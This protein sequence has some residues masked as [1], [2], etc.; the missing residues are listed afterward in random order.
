[1]IG[2][3]DETAALV[4]HHDVAPGD[5][6]RYEAWLRE[7]ASEAQRF[8]GHMGVNI[9]R[10]QDSS[11]RYTIVLRFDSNEHLENWLDSAT[12]KRFI[13]EIRPMLAKN[14]E[15]EIRTGLEYWFTPPDA[16]RPN[17]RPI[18]QFLLTL[19]AIFPLTVVLPWLLHPVFSAVPLFRYPLVT[20]FVLAVLIV[21]LMVYVIMPRY[22]KLV[23]KWLFR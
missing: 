18:K 21:F 3:D 15:I 13:E 17:A 8:S 4:V 12:R 23:S 14:E 7:I 1:M 19:S 20:K 6:S 22:T 10:P 11:A 16:K 9:I 5:R 2:R